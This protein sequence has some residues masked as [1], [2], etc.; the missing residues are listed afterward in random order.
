MDT[1]E[2][3]FDPTYGYSLQQLLAV[4]AP[5]EPK[6]FDGFWQTLY[7]KALTVAPQP[8]TK[9]INENKLQKG[10]QCVPWLTKN[11]CCTGMA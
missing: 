11:R 1:S 2:Y 3:G 5:K 7:Q 6:D 4:K 8:Q 10:S 9:I